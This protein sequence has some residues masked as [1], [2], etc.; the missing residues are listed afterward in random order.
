MGISDY[1][2]RAITGTDDA[3]RLREIAFSHE[4]RKK[5]FK[6]VLIG[7]DK[8]VK[9]YNK[10]LYYSRTLEKDEKNSGKYAEIRLS[11]RLSIE[12]RKRLD[13]KKIK[14]TDIEILSP[15]IKDTVILRK[16]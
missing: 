11:A 12:I 5:A 6:P 14:L 16:N 2:I 15:F 3:K 7:E 1:Y 9:A 10:L 8:I 4:Y 13:C